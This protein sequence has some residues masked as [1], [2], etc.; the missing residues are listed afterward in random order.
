MWINSTDEVEGRPYWIIASTAL[1]LA[2]I[3]HNEPQAS[4]AWGIGSLLSGGLMFLYSA[5]APR[6][7]FLWA[8]GIWGFSGLPFSPTA[9]G[10]FGLLTPGSTGI[11]LI[12]IVAQVLL[13]LGYARHANQIRDPLDTMEPWVKTIYPLGLLFIPIAMILITIAGWHGS[14]T[15]GMV[16]PS[17]VGPSLVVAGMMTRILR[18]TWVN[19]ASQNRLVEWS[20]PLID[21]ILQ[22]IN[23]FLRLNWLYNLTLFAYQGFK[24]LFAIITG[25][26]EGDGGVL[27]TLLLLTLVITLLQGRGATP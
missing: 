13:I 9:S 17:L 22:G 12:F 1:V 24:R 14:R 20:N 27:W 23:S 10:W 8:L 19:N 5:R 11:G 2:A 26:L 7:W 21:G 16:W 6:L 25:I 3:L 15:V 4:L 18:P